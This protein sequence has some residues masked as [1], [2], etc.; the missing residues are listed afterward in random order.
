MQAKGREGTHAVSVVVHNILCVVFLLLLFC[1]T[2]ILTDS[3]LLWVKEKYLHTVGLLGFH[4]VEGVSQVR[5][6]ILPSTLGLQIHNVQLLAI[7]HIN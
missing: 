3:L 7:Q 1:F 4:C 2:K 5:I 6:M